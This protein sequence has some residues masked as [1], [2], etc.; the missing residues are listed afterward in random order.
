MREKKALEIIFTEDSWTLDRHKAQGTGR[1]RKHAIENVEEMIE[2]Y[3]L[4]G[5]RRCRSWWRKTWSLRITLWSRHRSI[6]EQVVCFPEQILAIVFETLVEKGQK[7][8]GYHG[9]NETRHSLDVP[10]GE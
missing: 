6:L 1:T 10:P 3:S 4:H 7:E 2:D 5:R 8:D 9:S